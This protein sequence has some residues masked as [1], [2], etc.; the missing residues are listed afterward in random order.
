R[1]NIMIEAHP[2]DVPEGVASGPP[3]DGGVVHAMADVVEMP[4]RALE[5]RVVLV[6]G[7]ALAIGDGAT[8]EHAPAQGLV[9]AGDGVGLGDVRRIDV[10]VQLRI[11]ADVVA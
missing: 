2:I 4:V 7:V 11:L 6:A 8:G 3:A 9:P 10:A 1:T 5:R